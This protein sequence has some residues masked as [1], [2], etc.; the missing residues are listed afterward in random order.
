MELL[1]L[2]VSRLFKFQVGDIVT[3]VGM[4]D[5]Y[6]FEAMKSFQIIKR[7]PQRMVVLRQILEIDGK[8]VEKTY[9]L[10]A[11]GP[12]GDGSWAFR[13]VKFVPE[14][15]LRAYPE[16]AP[17]EDTQENCAEETA[18]ERCKRAYSRMTDPQ[19]L[20]FATWV[21]EMESGECH[22]SA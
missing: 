4:P 1:D 20:L 3:H 15:M 8:V 22:S 10:D 11:I 9:I 19:R 21:Q 2:N 14:A 12:N 6:E 18:Y 5:T 13:R 17:A 16:A 7:E